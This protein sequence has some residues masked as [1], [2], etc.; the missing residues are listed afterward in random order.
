M[1]DAIPQFTPHVRTVK[2]HEAYSYIHLWV[3]HHFGT[4]QFGIGLLETG[5]VAD[6]LLSVL[7]LIQPRICPHSAVTPQSVANP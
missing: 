3:N 2:T 5:R 1:Y 6:D 7:K 4:H